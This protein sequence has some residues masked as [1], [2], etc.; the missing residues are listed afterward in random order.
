MSVSDPTHATMATTPCLSI[1]G[2][3]GAG[4][5]TLATMVGEYLYGTSHRSHAAALRF[6][7]PLKDLCCNLYGWNRLLMDD[8]DYKEELLPAADQILAPGETPHHDRVALTTRREI[9]CYVG[10][11]MFRKTDED[12]WIKAA[13]RDME[14]HLQCFSAMKAIINTDCRYGNEQRALVNRCRSVKFVRINIAGGQPAWAPGSEHSSENVDALVADME[15]W[16]QRGDMYR[17]RQV[18]RVVARDFEGEFDA[19]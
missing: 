13:F 18:A 1:I 6:S 4:K 12:V 15:F 17:M 7:D 11:E 19:D 8:Y 10:T 5:D 3:A 16:V 9:L 2:Y 14:A